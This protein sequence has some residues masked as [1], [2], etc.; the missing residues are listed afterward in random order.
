MNTANINEML[1]GKGLRITKSRKAILSILSTSKEP[2]S[3][4]IIQDKFHRRKQ[5][6]H[7]TTL[8]RELETFESNNI[9]ESCNV[10]GSKKYQLKSETRLAHCIS[11]NSTSL[12]PTNVMKEIDKIQKNKNFSLKLETHLHGFCHN[13]QKTS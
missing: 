13:C 5:T 9:V 7:L 12:L 6:P 2:V 10:F 4:K 11:C 8:Y 1:K 3:I